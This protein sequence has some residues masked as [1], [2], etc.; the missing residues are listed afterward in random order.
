[1]NIR[2]CNPRIGVNYHAALKGSNKTEGRCTLL[3]NPFRVA[4]YLSPPTGFTRGCSRPI[5]SE[6][7]AQCCNVISKTVNWQLATSNSELCM[8]MGRLVHFPQPFR[9]HMRVYLCRGQIRVPEKFL[10][11]PQIGSCIEHMSRETVS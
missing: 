7:S 11:D 1:M 5:L 4:A 6:L 9:A 3:F 2:G 8:R 10:Y